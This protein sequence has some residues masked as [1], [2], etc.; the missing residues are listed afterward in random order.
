MPGAS[1]APATVHA[2]LVRTYCTLVKG[3]LVMTAARAGAYA[4][5]LNRVKRSTWLPSNWTPSLRAALIL[6]RD[7]GHLASVRSR[8]ATDR[9]G[10]PLPWYTY[11]AIQY[12]QQLDFRTKTIFEYGSG[13][14]TLFWASIAGR[15]VSVED[16]E[17]WFD[18]IA[19]RVPANATVTLQTDLAEFPAAIH[20][21]GERF[22]VIVVDGPARGRTRLKCCRAA[23]TALRSGGLIILDNSDWLPE[24]SRLLREHGLLQ[25]DMTGFAPICGH[26]Q[27]TSFF[28]DRRFDVLPLSGRQPDVPIGGAAGDWECP[29]MQ[30]EG[31]LIECDGEAFRAVAHD[32][33]FEILTTA[34]G[35]R[36]FRAFSYL[37]G[38]DL[39]CVAIVDRDRDRVL[40]TRHRPPD[41]ER[42]IARLA[43]MTWGEFRAFIAAHPKRR[44]VL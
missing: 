22:D 10:N 39:R 25:V 3:A 21:T 19:A 36:G 30:T 6:W 24:S 38:D 7:Y 17:Q 27:T 31:A 11:P 8:L 20:R 28:F 34:C 44:Y 16:D 41:A 35:P 33:S 29:L 1:F 18:T 14:S 9:A 2:F 26:V 42:E 23:L 37:G 13:M 32:T 12:L 4:T 43:A 15:V 5:I 40:L